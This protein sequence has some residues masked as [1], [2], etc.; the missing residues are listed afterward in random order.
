MTI[1]PPSEAD[2]EWLKQYAIRLG[3][4]SAARD[5]AKPK[6]RDPPKSDVQYDRDLADDERDWI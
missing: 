5:A 4:E 6:F 3:R 2:M 1:R